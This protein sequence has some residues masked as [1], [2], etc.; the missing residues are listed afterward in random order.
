[1]SLARE[2]I[3]SRIILVAKYSIF[4]FDLDQENNFLANSSEIS[5]YTTSSYYS[6]DISYNF[7]NILLNLGSYLR[8]LSQGK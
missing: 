2:P 8:F 7:K 6:M 5:L 3:N 4:L 1:M